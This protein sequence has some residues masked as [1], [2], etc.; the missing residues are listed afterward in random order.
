MAANVVEH[1]ANKADGN[2]P[3]Q[4]WAL[5]LAY[6]GGAFHGWQKQPDGL[7]TIQSVLEDA[8]SSIAA[9]PVNVVVAGRTDAG[10]HATGQV[11]HFDTYAQRSAEAWLRGTNTAMDKNIRIV[12]AQPVAAE[13]HA[14]FDAYGRRYRYMLESSRVRMPQLRGR[15]GWT[16]YP[17][18]MDLMR[19]AAEMLIGEH[20]FSSFRSS[21]CQ[22]KSPVKT[23][24]QLRLAGSPELMAIDFH[25]SAFVHNMVRNIVGALVYVGAGKLSVAGFAQL[26][27]AKSRRLAPPTF[28]PDGLYLTGVDYPQQWGV[29]TA[30]LPV[31]L[32]PYLN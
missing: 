24:Y 29:A 17:L 16:H 9:E 14:R 23:L 20:D 27:A 15:V 21:D 30:A 13:F 10:V 32:W 26:V 5:T 18:N 22:A 3:V 7:Y 19:E 28:M 12:R 31:W 8:L 11:V 1:S 6:D 25:G 4:R 2:R